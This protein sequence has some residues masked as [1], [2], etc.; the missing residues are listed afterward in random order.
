MLRTIQSHASRQAKKAN[1]E[2]FYSRAIEAASPSICG[3][4]IGVGLAATAELL[5]RM[6]V[7]VFITDDD[8]GFVTGDEAVSVIVPGEWNAYPAHPDVEITL[9]LSPRHMAYYSW[10]VPR[11]TYMPLDRYK[12]D[13]INS[14]TIGSCHKEFVSWKG[15]ARPEWFIGDIEAERAQRAAS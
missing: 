14:R 15:T 4:A 8:A 10:K 2:P 6:N 9:P 7:S 3:N 13:R 12:L 5:I 11:L 1:I